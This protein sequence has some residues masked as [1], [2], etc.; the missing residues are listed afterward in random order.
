MSLMGGDRFFSSNWLSHRVAA[1]NALGAL[2]LDAWDAFA[3]EQ[4]A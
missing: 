4:G 2:S 1:L 3:R